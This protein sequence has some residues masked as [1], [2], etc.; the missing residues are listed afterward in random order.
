MQGQQMTDTIS[1]EKRQVARFY[2]DGKRLKP[3]QLVVLTKPN[4]GA[5]REML[6]AKR[7]AK[8]HHSTNELCFI[9]F[10]NKN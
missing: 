9:G 4:K 2:Q 5:Y 6:V 8:N 7:K 1:I 3:G 10:V